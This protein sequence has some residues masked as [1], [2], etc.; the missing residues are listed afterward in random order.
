MKTIWPD[1]NVL[2][3]D[4][5]KND[6]QVQAEVTKPPTHCPNCNHHQIVGFGRR[7]ELIMDAPVNGKRTRITLTRRRYRC[8][9]CNKTFLEQVPHKHHKR[10]MTCR[11]IQYIERESLRRTFSAVAEA[12]GVDEKTVRNVV[13]D[14]ARLRKPTRGEQ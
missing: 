8:K 7:D 5:L 11:L 2:R 6:Y 12:V 4:A 13:H 9:G 1:Y 14:C 10:R 3:V